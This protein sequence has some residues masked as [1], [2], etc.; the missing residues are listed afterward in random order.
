MR[1]SENESTTTIERKKGKAT[2]NRT[3]NLINT[4][5]SKKKD[6]KN[7]SNERNKHEETTLTTT[8]L[9]LTFSVSY[10]AKKQTEHRAD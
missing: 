2:I 9:S 3:K 5:Y 7:V 4:K 6:A 1:A 10:P 8:C